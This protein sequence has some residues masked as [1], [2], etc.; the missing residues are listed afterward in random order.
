MLKIPTSASGF[1]LLA[2]LAVALSPLALHAQAVSNIVYSAGQTIVS[3]PPQAVITAGPSVVVANGASVTFQATGS[4]TLGDGFRAEAG[5]Y[6]RATIIGGGGGSGTYMLT[7]QNGSGGA[8][9]LPV[10]FVRTI[11]ANAPAN[12]QT[13]A[14][15][16]LVAGPGAIANSTASTTTFTVGEGDATLR[17]TYTVPNPYGDDDGDGILNGLEADLGT[18]PNSAATSDSANQTE[19]KIHKPQ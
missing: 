14:R 8:S 3:D 4:I 5:S 16:T 10:G 2:A 12:G 18:N 11:A 19:L 9:G 6:F 17:A 13:F 7:V 1:R 15:W